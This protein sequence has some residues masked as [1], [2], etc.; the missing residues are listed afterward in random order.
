MNTPAPTPARYAVL[1]NPVAHS[2]SPVIHTAFAEQTGEA[3]QYE[4]LLA[5]LD[6]FVATVQAFAEGGARGCNVTVPFKFQA[7]SLCPRHTPRAELAQ[8]AN[9]LRFDSDG[10]LADNTDG[11]GLMADIQ[12]AAGVPLR[13]QRVL[14]IGAGGAA[15]G[16]LGPLLE[17]RPAEVV[18]ANRTLAKAEALAARH[19]SLAQGLGVPLRASSLATP[20]DAFD[21][22][23]NSSA[24]SLGGG[25]VPVPACVL[26]AG[27]LAVD[28]MYGA[29]AEPFLAWACHHGA[30]ARDGLG[31][32]VEQAAESFAL[33]RGVRPATGQVMQMLRAQLAAAGGIPK[34]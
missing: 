14:L 9:T 4:R 31:M 33:W 16:V 13:G 1:G 6:G 24:S 11:V 34:P 10:W 30:V 12:L 8:A 15:A 3:V 21:V 25:E 22:V 20:G 27:T 17:T 26:R 32:L 7:F 5:P 18:V 28:L 29:A 19:A 23:L 2:R